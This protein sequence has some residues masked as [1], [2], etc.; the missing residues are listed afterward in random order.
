MDM[1]FHSPEAQE[2]IIKR[3]AALRENKVNI[4]S[5]S[6]TTNLV[7]RLTDT[8]AAKF[9]IGVTAAEA[10][11]LAFASRALDPAIVRVPSIVQFFTRPSYGLWTT[12]YL[13]MGFVPGT[14][15]DQLDLDASLQLVHR[16]DLII[17]HIH[18][19]HG[20]RPGP[21]DGSPARGLLWSDY[22]SGQRFGTRDHL[23]S[24][25]EVRLSHLQREITIDVTNMDLSFCHMDIAPRNIILGP[26][27][28]I[29]LVDW[30]CAGF[31]PS[32]FETWAIQLEAY[33]HGHPFMET[34]ESKLVKRS[35]CAEIAQIDALMHVYRA[36]QSVAFPNSDAQ[37]ETDYLMREVLGDDWNHEKMQK[38]VGE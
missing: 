13:V 37:N 1:D 25:L 6:N 27:N 18:S 17:Q 11:A 2:I 29:T 24:Y 35:S 32:I 34:L 30:G 20:N 22:T 15:L 7:V 28:S 5:H 10:E 21:L 19:F 36:N 38:L 3:C 9:G 14:P 31:Y 23:Q 12:G 4:L 16:V 8:I 26:D 33:I